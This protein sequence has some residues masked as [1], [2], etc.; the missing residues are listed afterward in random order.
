MNIYKVS[1]TDKIDYDEYDSFICYARD[2][3]E[4]KDI[5]PASY[6]VWDP[7]NKRWADDYEMDS[8]QPAEDRM[9]SRGWPVAADTLLKIE[10]IGK[11]PD[12]AK[13]GVIL[14]SFNAG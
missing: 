1:R 5:P 3:L 6:I 11:G 4:A 13:P 7:D 8:G 12:D 14:A 2:E 10:L 9:M